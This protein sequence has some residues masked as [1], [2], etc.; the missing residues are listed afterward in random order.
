MRFTS[1]KSKSMANTNKISAHV[2]VIFGKKLG[3]IRKIPLLSYTFLSEV[4]LPTL[5][6]C[7]NSAIIL[8]LTER[9]STFKGSLFK[10]IQSNVLKT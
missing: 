9:I 8:V 1:Y 5:Q 3:R 6:L 4:M 10:K 7:Q 2:N